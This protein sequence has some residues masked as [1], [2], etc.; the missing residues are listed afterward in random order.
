MYA[1]F[2][3]LTYCKC[4]TSV[5]SPATCCRIVRIAEF[6]LDVGPSAVNL[7]LSELCSLRL[8]LSLP[9]A[10]LICKYMVLFENDSFLVTVLLRNITQYQKYVYM[11]SLKLTSFFLSFFFL[12]YFLIRTRYLHVHLKQNLQLNVNNFFMIVIYREI[13]TFKNKKVQ[14]LILNSVWCFRNAEFYYLWKISYTRDY[15]LRAL[16]PPSGTK[17][18]LCLVTES[19]ISRPD[20]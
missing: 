2:T 13:W 19:I 4:V 3:A 14:E 6:Y 10:I 17:V 9:Y 5:T 15:T 8:P 7:C 18:I 11:Y 12:K 16:S 1:V 20:R